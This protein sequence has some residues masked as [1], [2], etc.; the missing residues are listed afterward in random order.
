MQYRVPNYYKEF[1]CIADQCE[2]TCCVG[3]QITVDRKAL[4][5]YGREKGGFGKRLRHSINWRTG[6]FRQSKGK[7]CMFLNEHNLCDIY[8]TL[9]E[10][11]LCKTC[12]RYPRHVE[13]FENV[14]ELTLS[15][16][17]PRVAEILLTRDQSVRFRTY[18]KE[19]VE[20]YEE[21]DSLLYEK[22]CDARET[23]RDIL[24]NRDMPIELRVKQTLCLSHEIQVCI[25]K[26]KI[27]DS[28]KVLKKYSGGQGTKNLAKSSLSMDEDKDIHK[29]YRNYQI[30]RHLFSGLHNLEQIQDTWDDNLR[31]TEQILYGKGFQNYDRLHE[32]FARW[33]E[34]YMPRWEIQCEQLVIYF[35]DTYFCGAV[36]D[37]MAYAKMQ[38]A[39]GS[40][41][42]IYEMMLARW[43]KNGGI[44]GTED[45]IRT[46]YC[47]SREIE[48]SDRNI[49]L[50]EKLTRVKVPVC[51]CKREE[52][53]IK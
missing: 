40:V 1:N 4:A 23:M 49:E 3:W 43:A 6:A 11:A 22:L 37:G 7:R 53:M 34:K 13:Q 26:K 20:F 5:R 38:M 8:A 27:A 51:R 44:L 31:E 32:K 10:E 2:A 24:Q 12:K 42:L 21:F 17:C 35:M 18:K 33:R 9:G 36:Y 19:S 46:V 39:V 16:S 50:L 45:V 47:Y 25:W 52:S 41:W 14:R 48:H 29:M 15:L 30:T 28:D